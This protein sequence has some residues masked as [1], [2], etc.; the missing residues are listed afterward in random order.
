MNSPPAQ[1]STLQ[2]YNGGSFQGIQPPVPVTYTNGSYVV[3][4]FGSVGYAALNNGIAEAPA[5][6]YFNIQQAY[7]TSCGTRYI[8]SP[9]NK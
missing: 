9:C 5:V 6:G 4:A 7:G 2:L 1:Y 3:P 8:N